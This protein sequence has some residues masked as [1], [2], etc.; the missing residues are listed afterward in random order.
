[1][2]INC[3]YT[4]KELGIDQF[5][6]DHFIPWSFVSHDLMWNLISDP[7]IN[8]SKSNKIPNLDFY[9]QKLALTH[10]T[11]LKVS[12]ET[13]RRNKLLEDYLS[14]GATPEEIITMSQSQLYNCFRNTFSPMVQIATNMGFETWNCAI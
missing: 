1:M 2:R 3:I 14:L 4:G 11:A 8:S 6:L 9:L 13:S 5:D 10:Q 12:F 7:S